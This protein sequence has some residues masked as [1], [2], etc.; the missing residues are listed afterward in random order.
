MCAR[1]ACRP[2]RRCVVRALT[3]TRTQGTK[4]VARVE[5]GVEAGQYLYVALQIALADDDKFFAGFV[6]WEKSPW[7]I[8]EAP[9]ECIILDSACPVGN[10]DGEMIEV[11]DSSGIWDLGCI[12]DK[13]EEEEEEDEDEESMSSEVERE[14][15]KE[16]FV[17]EVAEWVNELEESEVIP[18]EKFP[19]DGVVVLR[20]CFSN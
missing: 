12:E 15:A 4:K 8:F 3:H 2:A 5:S 19:C 7:R 18:M 9:S 16:K 6:L 20:A 14:Q 17:A 11:F 10:E 13:K 1:C